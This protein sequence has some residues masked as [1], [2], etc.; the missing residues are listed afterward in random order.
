MPQTRNPQQ[1]QQANQGENNKPKEAKDARF[2]RIAGKRT[3]DAIAAIE[4]V[5]ATTRPSTY[6]YTE[7]QATKIVEA[8]E[9]AVAGVRESFANKG[10]TAATFDL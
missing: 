7:E 10:G 2:K 5:G 6:T 4:K 1:E 9:Q 3:A 8:L